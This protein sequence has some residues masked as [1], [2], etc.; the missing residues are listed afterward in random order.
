MNKRFV[1]AVIAV[2]LPFVLSGRQ[3]DVYYIAHDHYESTLSK[4]VTTIWNTA[5]ADPGRT[6]VVYLANGDEPCV[7]VSPSQEGSDLEAFVSTLNSR[8]QHNVYPESDR[9]FFI[10]KLSGTE[11]GGP[12]FGNFDRVVFHFYIN[13]SFVEM[14]YCNALIARLY[15]DM[16]MASLPKGK[17]AIKIYYPREDGELQKVKASSLFGKERLMG[18]FEPAVVLF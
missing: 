2:L 13:R 16:E 17:L 5:T 8:S 11:W 4:L 3:L 9:K 15:W 10:E 14:G 6:V 1:L 12:G 7:M 18:M